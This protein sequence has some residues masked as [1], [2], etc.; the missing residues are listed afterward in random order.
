MGASQSI[1]IP[2]R[3]SVLAWAS[4][5]SLIADPLDVF[6]CVADLPQ[7]IDADYQARAGMLE[8]ILI[9]AQVG[10]NFAGWKDR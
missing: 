6:A 10:I 9:F 2:S 1:F 4:R 3:I 7:V 8:V 5:P